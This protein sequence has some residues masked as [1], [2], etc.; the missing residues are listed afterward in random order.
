[1]RD[2]RQYDHEFVAT[3]TAYR[4]RRPNA[5]DQPLGDQLQQAIAHR[6][7]QRIVDVLEPVEV[8]IQHRE[9]RA[10]PLRRQQRLREQVV[11]QQSVRQIG[12]AVVLGEIGQPMGERPG[13]ADI[14]EDHHGPHDGAASIMNRCR[15]ILDGE[16]FAVAPNQDA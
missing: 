13:R 8:Q 7:A 11:Q 12:Q 2:L 14:V 1:M 4:V 9:H 16:L 5:F 3:Q 15:G 6:V 10:V